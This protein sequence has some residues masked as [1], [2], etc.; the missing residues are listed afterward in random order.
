MNKSITP[1]P[2]ANFTPSLNSY[3]KLSPFRF[4]CQKVLPLV[5]DDSLSYY[6]LLCKVVDYLNKIMENAL[7][8]QDDMVELVTAYTKLQNYVNNY[9][10]DL[11]IQ[12]E[13]NN[14]LDSMVESGELYGYINKYL[15]YFVSP[16]SFGAVGDGVSD[17][18]EAFKEMLEGSP[19]FIDLLGKTYL[20]SESLTFSNVRHIKNGTIKSVELYGAQNDALVYI[21]TSDAVISNITVDCG[22][23]VDRPFYGTA[24]YD[25]YIELRGKTLTSMKLTGCKNVVVENCCGQNALNGIFIT[26][27][28]NIKVCNHS[29]YRTM[30]DGIY[31]TG[32]SSNI[33][34]ENSSCD[35]V[36]DDCFSVNGFSQNIDDNPFNVT[37]NNCVAKNSF[38]A[39][40]T[41]LS[42]KNCCASNI[43]SDGNKYS[44]IKLGALEIS[45]NYASHSENTVVSNVLVNLGFQLQL[46]GGGLIVCDGN[47]EKVCSH[48]TLSNIN[49]N[50]SGNVVD[51]MFKWCNYLT[52][53][54]F[55]VNG[56]EFYVDSCT[57]VKIT[58][59]LLNVAGVTF[60]YATNVLFADNLV[61][62]TGSSAV[63]LGT[64]NNVIIENIPTTKG[65]YVNNVDGLVTSLAP[66][67][68]NSRNIKTSVPVLTNITDMLSDGSMV[69]TSAGKLGYVYEGSL[70]LLN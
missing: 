60:N 32:K 10:S 55:N 5:Y 48:I 70:V 49:I 28:E 18:T 27:C 58:G 24:G 63:V 21:N 12:T 13:I 14:K 7:T 45:E 15:N 65:V 41:L 1:L 3:N 19:E 68:V 52:L 46:V 56:V 38:G 2:E 23:Y 17:D 47:S 64:C 39:A 40:V 36:G 61:Y 31:I 59:S 33:M 42:C 43:V 50:Y 22:T 4:W 69:Y 6:E 67:G 34:V 66:N 9:F 11:N 20:V 37:F 29:A 44:P 51:M 8:L 57:N 30:A 54:N 16:V 62:V 26:G 35:M 53:N 25:E